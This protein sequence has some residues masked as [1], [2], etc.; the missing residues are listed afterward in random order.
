MKKEIKYNLLVL[1]CIWTHFCKSADV[2]V[3]DSTASFS[4]ANTSIELAC[5]FYGLE[6]ERFNSADNKYSDLLSSLAKGAD[7]SA[8]LISANA[9]STFDSLEILEIFKSNKLFYLIYD[10]NS[11]TDSTLLN[12]WSSG[13]LKTC[14]STGALPLDSYYKV[15][16]KPNITHELAGQYLPISQTTQYNL[17]RLIINDNKQIIPILTVTNKNKKSIFPFFV[18]TFCSNTEVFF[19]SEV[20]KIKSDEVKRIDKNKGKFSEIETFIEICPFLIFLKYAGG[21]KCWHSNNDYANFTIDDPWLVEPY[22]NLS[23]KNLLSE[24]DK[25]NFHT[26]IAFIPWN[27]DRCQPDVIAIF[28]KRSDRFSIC[29]HGDNHDHREF[30][31]YETNSNDTYSAKSI[32]LQENLIKQSLARMERLQELTGLS[33]DKVMIFPHRTSPSKT[34][35][36]LKKYNFGATVNYGKVPLDE[37]WPTDLYFWLKTVT[38]NYENF[39]SLDRY[40]TKDLNESEIAIDLYLDN[41]ILFFEHQDFFFKGTDAF[42]EIAIKVNSIQPKVLWRRLGD[43][44]QNLYLEKLGKD[45]NY[46]IKTFSS[47]IILKNTHKQDLTFDIIKE[48]SY[49]VPIRKVL[50]EGKEHKFQKNANNISLSVNLKRDEAKNIVFEYENDFIAKTIDITK[51]DPRSEKLRKLSDFRDMHLSTNF[52]GRVII[53]LY[54][55]KSYSEI[56]IKKILLLGFIFFIAIIIITMLIAKRSRLTKNR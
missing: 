11:K 28:K 16:E 12:K 55:N 13:A 10:V 37:E 46:D 40:L 22:G 50:V 25:A 39:P 36:L 32:T 35:G 5:Q 29:I 21:E 34:L 56:G 18:Q 41:P 23:F 45:G 27:Y 52:F 26:T 1:F 33:Y 48:E 51:N 53:Q 3:V 2:L 17:N 20:S 42:N 19:L 43:I 14:M 47:N 44:V 49:T 54:Y 24:M 4:Q 38:L 9:L 30:Y 7:L 31:K 8:I 6:L 15:T